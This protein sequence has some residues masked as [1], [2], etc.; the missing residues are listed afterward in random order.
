MVWGMNAADGGR[1][2]SV[3]LG[4]QWSPW[5]EWGL[6]GGRGREGQRLGSGQAQFFLQEVTLSHSS[7]LVTPIHTA[8]VTVK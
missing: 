4:Y 8:A 2:R 3:T 5:G 6:Q 7:H 1:E